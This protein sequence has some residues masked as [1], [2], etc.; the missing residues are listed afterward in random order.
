VPE[1]DGKRKWKQRIPMMAEGITDSYL[2]AGREAKKFYFFLDR[3]D[4]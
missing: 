3:Y 4:R 1:I 2:E